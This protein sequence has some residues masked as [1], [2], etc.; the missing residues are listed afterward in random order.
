MDSECFHLDL[1]ADGVP[2]AKEV[3]GQS[4]IDHRHVLRAL[5]L[6]S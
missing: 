1:L 6:L 5:H 3:S 4:L 2:L